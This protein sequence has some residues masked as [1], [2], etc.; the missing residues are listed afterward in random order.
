MKTTATYFQNAY[1]T[2]L[3]AINDPGPYGLQETFRDVSL[4]SNDRNSEILR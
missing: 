2:A 1:D 3:A 4:G